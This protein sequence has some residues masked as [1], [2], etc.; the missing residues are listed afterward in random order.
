MFLGLLYSLTRCQCSL[1]LPL[2][3]YWSLRRCPLSLSWKV[4]SVLLTRKRFNQEIVS[5]IFLPPHSVIG[6][7]DYICPATNQC[8]IDK[9][10]RKSCQACRLRKCYEVGMVKCGECLLPF[11]LYMGLAKS[12]VLSGTGDSSREERRF[13]T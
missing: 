6:H 1:T 3:L 8:T 2:Y 7:N 10:R 5:I 9:N 4:L 12:P 13:R 11:L